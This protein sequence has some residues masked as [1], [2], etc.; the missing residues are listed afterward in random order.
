MANRRGLRFLAKVYQNLPAEIIRRPTLHL[1]K[2]EGTAPAAT[3]PEPIYDR[4]SLEA[5][6]DRI[7]LLLGKL[8]T[9]KRLKTVERDQD[10]LIVRV[11]DEPLN[12]S[13]AT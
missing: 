2:K 3:V 5:R 1:V 11:I 7:E 8:V 4:A 10:D 13:E 9:Q 6:L 12:E